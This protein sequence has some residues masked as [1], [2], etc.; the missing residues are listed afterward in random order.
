MSF[1]LK[2]TSHTQNFPFPAENEVVYENPPCLVFVPINR[3]TDYTVTVKDEDENVVF[4]KTT[5]KNYVYDTK[6]WKSGRY[7]WNVTS[8]SGKE[9]GTMSFTLSEDAI[10]AERPD[11]K[12]VFDSIPQDLRPR[13]LFSAEDIPALLEDHKSDLEILKRNAE[14]AY[15]HGLPP[16]PKFHHYTD[17]LPYREY[18]GEY[19]D[20]CDRDLIA[21][22]L[23]YALTGDK[24]SAD[25]AKNLLLT[26]CDMNPL[27]P[28]SLM[29]EWGDEV[30]LSNARCLPAAFDMLFDLLDEKQRKYVAGT[31]AIYARQCEAR[32]KKINYAENP[33]HS[34]VGRLPAYLGEAALVLKGT[35]VE[36]DEVLT[37]W[38]DTALDIYNGI[39]PFYGCRDGSWAEGAFFST[40][41]TKWYLPFFSAVE[42]FSQKSL[43]T[44][45]FYARYTQYLL[46]FC[47]EKFENHP[48][49]DG[50]WSNPTDAEWP[51][52]FAQNPYRVYADRF[53]PEL[54]KSRMKSVSD[55]DYFRLH[56][57]D[58]FLPKPGRSI[59]TSLTGEVENCALFPEG[60]FCAM[61]TDI[62][63]DKDICVMMRASKYTADSHR[64][65]DQGSFALFYKGLALISPSGYF[66]RKYGSIHHTEWTKKTVAHNVALINGEGQRGDIN[67]TGRFIEFDKS[68]RV[69]KMDITKSYEK[70]KKYERT[71]E[72]DDGGITV[73]DY[74]EADEPV[75][76]KY[77]LHTLA[78]PTEENGAVTIL[79]DNCRM[80]IN[81]LCGLKLDFVTDKFD[82]DL[83][84]GVESQYQVSM[85]KQYH[86][87]YS[88][89][90]AEKHLLKV[91]FDISDL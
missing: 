41:Y 45:P 75:T 48:F 16:Y 84:E 55:I 38:L 71:V 7:F 4:E 10:I 68:N 53:G 56:L 47:N 23:L 82:V 13:H 90:A 31:I 64:H 26:I 33:S 42:R 9:R 65:A 27:G 37:Y 77:P 15:S 6:P 12:S 44:R 28:C 78:L 50:Y 89:D 61:H 17:A 73:T 35:G 40:S 87:Y 59:A 86:V 60:G 74:I 1:P 21:C 43:F 67:A 85:P 52:F 29:G 20:Y 62:N 8:D 5:D 24:K 54:A 79:R 22:S 58:I 72:L 32:I 36:S 19:R 25:H 81:V 34:H 11:A 39:F 91:R 30:G 66:G 3:K 18:F 49:G 63:S 83:N 80:R 14:I 76:V 88:S 57:L 51:G 69:A 46:H 2:R 70:I